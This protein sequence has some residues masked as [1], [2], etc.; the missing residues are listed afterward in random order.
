M[1]L[2]HESIHLHAGA[3]YFDVVISPKLFDKGSERNRNRAKERL[4]T[5]KLICAQKFA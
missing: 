1:K 5:L 3:Y 2:R 4:V